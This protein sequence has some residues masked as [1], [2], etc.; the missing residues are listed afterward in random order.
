MSREYQLFIT[1]VNANN[2]KNVQ[3]NVDVE[4]LRKKT[5]KILD[6]NNS[7]GI[8][9]WVVRGYKVNEMTVL[10]QKCYV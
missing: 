6:A 1:I 4:S 5:G 10:C 3:S 2:C 7:K 8:N 9:L